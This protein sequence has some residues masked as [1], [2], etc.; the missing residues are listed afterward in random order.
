MEHVLVTHVVM[1][2]VSYQTMSVTTILTASDEDN[3]ATSMSL[4]NTFYPEHLR[5]KMS[6]LHRPHR[7]MDRCANIIL[8]C[9]TLNLHTMFCVIIIII[10]AC[11]Y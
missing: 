8:V 1:V 10:A 3:R 7:H 2:S 9:S 6:Q 5:T 11:I 4:D